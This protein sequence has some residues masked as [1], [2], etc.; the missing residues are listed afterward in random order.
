M[1]RA[2]S[3]PAALLLIALLLYGFVPAGSRTDASSLI[4]LH[5]RANSDAPADQA[6]KYQVRNAVL[7]A[8]REYLYP[9]Q[10]RP[11]AEE[12]LSLLL[13]KLRETALLAVQGA[14]F[15]YQ[16]QVE[17]QDRDFPTR[18]YG[19]RLYRAGRYRTLDIAIGEAGGQNWW[20][21]LFPPLCFLET[22]GEAA[23]SVTS[24]PASP[25]RLKS[26]LLEWYRRLPGRQ[27]CF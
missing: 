26:R 19:D 7:S 25:P 15:A 4:R 21:V 24:P 18:L 11:E 14:G 12:M 22:P 13:P 9:A 1:R 6:L 16:V 8:C 3:L 5:V 20:C 10:T 27:A 2:D 17:L 23:Q